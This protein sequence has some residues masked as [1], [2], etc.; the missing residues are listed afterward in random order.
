MALSCLLLDMEE[1]E[2]SLFLHYHRHISLLLSTVE[3]RPTQLI[4]CHLH[5]TTC[6]SYSSGIIF[7]LISLRDS[8][9]LW[10]FVEVHF[11]VVAPV[12][13]EFQDVCDSEMTICDDYLL[14]SEQ[15]CLLLKG[16]YL[17]TC[18]Y[19][20]SRFANSWSSTVNHNRVQLCCNR[21]PVQIAISHW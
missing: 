14:S 21:Y 15:L 4:R 17:S 19:V 18:L 20:P 12:N 3:Y 1:N 13:S 16:G 7:L 5:P 8:L 11:Q 9:I 6:I 10:N 2:N